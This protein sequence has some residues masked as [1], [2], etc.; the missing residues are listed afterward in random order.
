LDCLE[1]G[2]IVKPPEGSSVE[3]DAAFDLY[4]EAVEDPYG[5]F[6][7]TRL[8]VQIRHE[9]V[10]PGTGSRFGTVDTPAVGHVGSLIT[11]IDDVLQSAE[12]MNVI[13]STI[14][15]DVLSELEKWFADASSN[16]LCISLKYV[17]ASHN[18]RE[19]VVNILG[20]HL[21]RRAREG[22]FADIP[23]VVSID[24]AHQ[25]LGR[26]IGDDST[27]SRLDAFE[28]I[29]KEGRKYGLTLCIATQRPSDL[30]AGMLS[31]VGMMIIHRIADGQDRQMVA[32]AAAEMD[33]SSLQL[34]PGLRQGEA[35]VMGVDLPVPVAVRMQRPDCPPRS[36]GPNYSSGWGIGR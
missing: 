35:V 11:R 3:F 8:S 16:V 27:S 10:K 29:A 31:Q 13:G 20:H 19:I 32:A 24:E 9:C 21:L 17:P 18:L 36:D 26:T 30:P 2:A 34:L 15:E 5:P 7:L 22:L 6:D 14:Q 25:F 12:V 33:V 4:S 1:D 23:L 28:L